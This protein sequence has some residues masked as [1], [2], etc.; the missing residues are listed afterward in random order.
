MTTR[1]RVGPADAR[2]WLLVNGARPELF[3]ER[4]AS[5]ADQVVDVFRA[6][7]KRYP[8]SDAVA[9]EFGATEPPP[10]ES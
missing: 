9:A 2:S 5:R 4:Y 3:D 8:R 10:D 7:I 1:R 6:A